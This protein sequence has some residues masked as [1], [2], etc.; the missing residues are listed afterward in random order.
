MPPPPQRTLVT[1][2]A[3]FVGSRLAQRLAAAG[4]DVVAV[5][6]L[7]LGSWEN[8]GEARSRVRTVQLDVC[9]PAFAELVQREKPRRIF[10]FAANSDISR[11]T[12]EPRTDLDRTFLTSYHTLEAMRAAGCRE[13]VFSSSSAIYGEAGGALREDKGPLQP[14]S[15]YGAAKLASEGYVS[16]Y[17]HL[18]NLRAWVFRFPNVVG[19]NLTH[20]ALYDFVRSLCRDGSVLRVLGDGTQTKPY[21]HVDDLIDAILLGVDKVAP[22][23]GPPQTYNVAG[24][25]ATSVREIAELVREAMRLP[26]ARIEYGKGDRGWPGDV[27][28]FAYDTSRIRALGWKPRLDS[29]AAVRAAI[30]AEVAKC[31]RSS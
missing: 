4:D 21:L 2:G 14:I 23:G 26:G 5:D 30:E 28:R 13:L 20:G 27:P 22:E 29:S 8:L 7:S 31:K 12:A 16:A 17:A 24:E 6:D 11:G 3:G 9:T 25:G 15:L 18:H 19:P 1:G 10:H